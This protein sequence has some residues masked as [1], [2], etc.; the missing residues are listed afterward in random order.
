MEKRLAETLQA[1]KEDIARLW[2]QRVK[3]SSE[4]YRQRPLDEIAATALRFI[5]GLVEALTLGDYEGIRACL[6]DV[7]EMRTGQGFA[8]EELQ[9]A[10]LMGCECIF[11]T[12]ERAF[13]NDARLLVWS[14]TQIER[15]I[16]RSIGLLNDALQQVQVATMETALAEAR[17]D[18]RGA[19]ARLQA[20][21]SGLGYGA[22]AVDPNMIVVWS[23]ARARSARCG[24][25]QPGEMHTCDPRRAG[26]EC[27][28][29]AA[30]QTGRVQR[31]EPVDDCT[32][33]LAVPVKDADGQVIEA[34]GII[35]AGSEADLAEALDQ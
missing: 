21:L 19:E 2:A 11:P 12:L 27:L 31:A 22:L 15:A 3:Q 23:D 33:W 26:R 25:I 9:R 10:V 35:G 5:D 20:I 4:R 7:A 29:T 8:P 6:A 17:A 16:H 32:I 24:A 13:G 18:R 30:L 34:V 14:V 28:L 1:G